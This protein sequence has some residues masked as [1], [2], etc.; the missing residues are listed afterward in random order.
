MKL[1]TR[2]LLRLP[3]YFVSVTVLFPTASDAVNGSAKKATLCDFCNVRLGVA[4]TFALLKI[5]ATR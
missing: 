3:K 1:L 2:E 5:D 4:G